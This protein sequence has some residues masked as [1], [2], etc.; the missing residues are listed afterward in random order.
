MKLDYLSFTLPIQS[1]AVNNTSDLFYVAAGLLREF[2]GRE[3]WDFL[4]DGQAFVPEAAR[5]PY[6]YSVR[7]MDGGIRCYGGP[8]RDEILYEMTGRAC[9]PLTNLDIASDFIRPLTDR[10]T[11]LDLAIDYE[12]DVTPKQFV[13]AG[14]SQ[15]FK[16][17]TS[18][19]SGTGQTEYVGSMKSE[20]MARVYRYNEPHPRAG[21]LRMEAVFR[22]QRAKDCAAWL[23]EALSKDQ[24]EAQL[25]ETF[26][27]QHPLTR[28]G[29]GHAEP[30]PTTR[31][32]RTAAGT[33]FWIYKQCVPAIARAIASG[34][35]NAV[36]F[37]VAVSD[38]VEE[39]L[40]GPEQED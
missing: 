13:D 15:R 40:N 39:L 7:R 27:F 22:K 8:G 37:H 6:R 23:T 38:A 33:V 17:T 2:A 16:T 24:V 32:D 12:T 36:D 19:H 21:L 20:L 29:Y 11:R 26:G 4:E 31:N 35:L 14:Y 3:W 18:M 34:D 1:E 10:I 5:A 30:I 28:H 25:I 9:D